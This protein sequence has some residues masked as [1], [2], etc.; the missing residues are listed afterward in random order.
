MSLESKW[1]EIFNYF[2]SNDIPCNNL[3]ILVEYCMCLSGTNSPVERVFTHMNN[4]WTKDK[5]QLHVETLKSLLVV[6]TNFTETC[7]EF[8]NI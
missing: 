1:V 5:S 7:V 3:E 8:Y 4:F 6:K 2:S